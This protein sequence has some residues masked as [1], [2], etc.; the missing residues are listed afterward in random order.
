MEWPG[1]GEAGPLSV[2]PHHS[3]NAAALSAIPRYRK[4]LSRPLKTIGLLGGMSSESTV[5]YYQTINRTVNERLGG[6]HSAR[7]VLYNVD[8]DPIVQAL[9]DGRWDEILSALET[10]TGALEAAGA[11]GLV[12]CTNTIHAVAP[13]LASRI[14]IPLLHIVDP[15]A[16]AIQA[17]GIR[18]VGL[19]G[20]RFTMEQP[21]F[22]ERL[23]D[24]H[25]IETIIPDGSDRD[26]LH[27]VIFD[28]LCHGIIRDES[29][30]AY[31]RVIGDLGERGAEGVILG[32]TE[33]AMLI[34]PEDVAVPTFDTT[35]LHARS[36]ACWALDA[37]PSG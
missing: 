26:V 25:G 11:E 31:Q 8:F 27:R 2:S 14:G 29:R 5:P 35:E 10:A 4:E 15:T 24:R 1:L 36:A 20:T 17:A 3:R 9:N 33:I 19:L 34:G 6:H 13:E 18:T 7:L 21:F 22:R 28:E 37:D 16:D 32:C 23:A 30:H 12:I